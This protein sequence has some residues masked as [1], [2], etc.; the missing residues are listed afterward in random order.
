M[1]K[2][3][4]IYRQTKMKMEKNGSGFQLCVCHI[5]DCFSSATQFIFWA[6]L[7]LAGCC[8]GANNSECLAEVLYFLMGQIAEKYVV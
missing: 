5:Y 3:E 4:N 2:K 6:P 7:A 8:S 1:E